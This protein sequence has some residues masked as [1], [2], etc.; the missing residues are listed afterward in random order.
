MGRDG[1]AEPALGAEPAGPVET[2]E[3]RQGEKVGGCGA[4]QADPRVGGVS[5]AVVGGGRTG[6]WSCR[7]SRPEVKS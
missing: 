3:G 6:R 2:P 5:T 4:R 7:E 1:G